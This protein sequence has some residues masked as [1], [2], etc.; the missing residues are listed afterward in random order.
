F[1]GLKLHLIIDSEG[2][3]IK[4][5]FISGNKDDRKGLKGMISGIYSGQL[6]ELA[7]PCLKISAARL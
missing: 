1:Y 6:Q 3:L 5:S 7:S 4:V 2:N